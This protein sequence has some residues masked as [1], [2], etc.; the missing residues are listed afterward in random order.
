MRLTGRIRAGTLES[1]WDGYST[2]DAAE[3]VGLPESTIRGCVR[4]GFVTPDETRVPMKLSFRDLRVLQ[5]V[6]E[7]TRGGIPLRRVRRQLAALV[8]RLPAE[9][10]LA[11]LSLAA[12]GGHVVVRERGGAWHAD[13]GQMVLDFPG[14]ERWGQVHPIPLRREAAGPEPV[15]G[16]TAD[17]WFERAVTLEEV[18]T[19]AAVGAYE[20]A[21]RLRRDSGEIWVNLGRLHAEASR[22]TEAARCFREALALD[23]ADATAIYNLGVVAQDEGRDR[24]A[25]E[26]YRRA[27][28]IDP[29]L[30]EAHYNLATLFDRSGDTRAAIRHINEYRKLTRQRG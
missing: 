18:D 25:I 23:P 29:A 21:L 22:T 30:A 27:L 5:A 17:D 24:E 9:G 10:S 20:R 16:L 19:E 12:H 26:L 4:A 11:E 28:R 2:R 15:D 8:Q 7:L 13:T 6:K 3:F 14:D 1:V